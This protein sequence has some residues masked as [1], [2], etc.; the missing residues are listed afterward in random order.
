VERVSTHPFS[1]LALGVN[2]GV[3][4]VGFQVAT[5]LASR[6][7][8]RGGASFLS[9]SPNITSDGVS[10]NGAISLKTAGASVDLF[11]FGGSFRISPGMI[12]YNGNHLDAIASVS[13]GQTFSLNSVSYTASSQVNGTFDMVFGSKVAPS[14]TVGFGNMIPHQAG[15]HWSV[16]VEVGFEYIGTPTI[17]FALSGTV[18]QN[19]TNCQPISSN[20][21]T[22]ANVAAEQTDLNNDVSALRFYP[23]AT[24]GLSY[25]FGGFGGR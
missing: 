24:I 3:G 13:S 8:L 21:Q 10:L 6:I 15:Q 11:P 4:G 17:A 20:T 18:C 9:V 5:P 16:P 7:N 22:Q 14:L 12:L 19:G 25:K 2:I 23:I 1:A